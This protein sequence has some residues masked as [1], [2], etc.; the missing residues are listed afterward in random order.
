MN[1][2]IS[3]VSSNVAKRRAAMADRLLLFVPPN[4]AFEKGIFVE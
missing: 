4:S 1:D 2:T 3:F